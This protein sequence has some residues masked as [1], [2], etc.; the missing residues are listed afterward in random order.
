MKYIRDKL[1]SGTRGANMV[2]QF[3][4]NEAKWCGAMAQSDKQFWIC[5]SEPVLNRQAEGGHVTRVVKK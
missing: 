4:T 5:F 2:L 1:H 3:L